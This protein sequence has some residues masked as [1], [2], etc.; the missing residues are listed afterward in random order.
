MFR[1]TAA[2]DRV[3][4]RRP[5]WQ[6]HPRL[7]LAAVALLVLALWLVPALLRMSGITRSVAASRLTIASVERGRFVRDL[8][9]DGKVVAAVS[10][11]LYAPAAGSLTLKVHAGD[12]VEKGQLLAFIDSPDLAARL[13]QEQAALQSQTL[14]WK[15]AQL[16]AERDATQAREAYRQAEV[17]HRTA[18]RELDRSRKAYEQGAYSELQVLKAQDA[19]EKAGFALEQAQQALASQPAQSRFDVQ[20]RKAQVDRQQ[21][22]VD[23]LQRQVD[24]LNLTSPVE[25][26]VGQVLVAD[27]ASIAK[28]A[29][30]LSVVDLSAL[31]VE[32][33][34]PEA[35]ARDLAVG[36]PAELSG[37][38]GQWPGSVS[39][40]SP[41]VVGGQ[42]VTRLR[43]G[44]A[45]PQGLRQSQR[46]SVR[47][48]LD[49]RDEVLMVDRGSF[50]D[51]DGGAYA[52]VVK[53][54][55]AHRQP[56]RLGAR[57]IAKVEILEGLH[58]G[59]QI[60]TSGTE[61]LEGEG[62]VA[63]TR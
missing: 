18:Q 46:L 50:A 20:A 41:E 22:L 40:V 2:Q 5:L 47:I 55:V 6:R 44:E 16:D 58:E 61:A 7:L 63:V 45:K 4:E 34:V 35:Y 13:A 43:F 53:D 12:K 28:D 51:A 25:G 33:Q 37:G 36:M 23:D 29:P 52:W 11:T 1:D 17:D 31:E 32:I 57:S 15:R 38:G 24:A 30:L 39:G 42:V 48:V 60:V 59:Q 10:P 56:V 9:A 62:P 19:L 21:V 26:Q 8:S 49:A 27:R 14:D 54:G 3:V